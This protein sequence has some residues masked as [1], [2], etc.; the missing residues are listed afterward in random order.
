MSPLPPLSP[1]FA[2]VR[3]VAAWGACTL[4]A[5]CSSLPTLPILGSA[6][7]EA[8]PARLTPAQPGGLVHCTALA[9]QFGHA[10]TRLTEATL[11]PAGK[12][13]VAGQPVAEHCRV[14]GVMHE[15]TSTVD[16]QSYAIGFEMRLPANWNGRFLHQGNGGLD[17]ILALAT[18][19]A[20]GRG[21]PTHGLH[22]GFAVLS[23]DAGHNV[24]QLPLFGLDPQ[25]RRDYG[26]QAVARLTPMAKALVAAAYG[27]GPD[28][29][30]FSGCSNGGRHAF[31][32]AA[33]LPQ[34]YDGILAGSPGYN[35]PQA[36]VAQVYGAQQ[37]ARVATD[38]KDLKTALTPAERQLITRQVLARC[39]ALDG[40]ADGLVQDSAACQR[41]FDL[42]RDVP[43]CSGE[44]RTG[45]CLTTGQ[46]SA[47]SAVLAGARNSQGR[48]L[49]S[50]FPVDAGFSAEDWANWK[51]VY[52][53]TNRDPVA[54]GFVFMVPPAPREMLKDTLGYALNF[55]MDRDAPG[56]DRTDAVYTESAMS[57]MTPP[58]PIELQP[59]R[60]R[61]AKMMV[62]H[63]LS[64]GVFSPEASID[65]YRGLQQRQAGRAEDFARLYLVPGM[66]HC[67]G[68]PATDA[69]NL[70]QPL[71][72]WV[73]RGQ[74]PEQI[75]AG[76]RGK[77]HP[78]GAN[79]ELPPD[80]SASR[81]R[82]LCAWPKVAR[83]QGGNP[84]QAASFRC[85]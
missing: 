15:R 16:G 58:S 55:S 50:G 19:P 76:A 4:L 51:F 48:A 35:L 18:G 60:Q 5:G 24:K 2:L 14:T 68:G 33:R 74:A 34:D 44:Q 32:T 83:F 65:W 78:G 47:L 3:S 31:V 67:G 26:Y 25:A 57:F 28:R 21:T 37:F 85:E 72:D 30:Y 82:P 20:G 6:T 54:L 84:E 69:F 43:S 45:Q 11:E 53:V 10:D 62:W 77:G 52:S 8:A 13:T 36:A 59:L 7:T 39:D 71:V 66:N 73:E 40:L 27:R 81:T 41:A 70:L 75:V 49:Y 79:A 38:P 22:M 29:S 17:G 12:L 46:K 42:N 63:G 80:W 56:I 23:S 9:R 64:D 1:P 61:G